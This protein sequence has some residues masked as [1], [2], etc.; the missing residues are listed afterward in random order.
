MKTPVTK[1]NFNKAAL[2]GYTKARF[3]AEFK[4]V[5][6]DADLA[7]YAKELGLSDKAAAEDKNAQPDSPEILTGGPK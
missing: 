5:Y 6:P 2:I 3:I 4:G 7:K 1:I